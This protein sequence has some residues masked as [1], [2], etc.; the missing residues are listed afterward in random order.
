ME[1]KD[2]RWELL[3]D[4]LRLCCFIVGQNWCKDEVCHDFVL[5]YME[6]EDSRISESDVFII[7][8]FSNCKTCLISNN[9]NDW[10]S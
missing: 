2:S 3:C 7:V 8:L 9:F 10:V 1:I 4:I 6:I 5:G